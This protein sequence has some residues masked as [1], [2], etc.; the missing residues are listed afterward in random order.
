MKQAEAALLV[1]QNEKRR[2]DIEEKRLKIDEQQLNVHKK[3]Q[4]L[5]QNKIL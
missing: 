4:E 2:L 3:L 1:A 5:L